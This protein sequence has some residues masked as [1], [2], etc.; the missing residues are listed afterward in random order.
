MFQ[1]ITAVKRIALYGNANE[2]NKVITKLFDN[3]IKV[4]N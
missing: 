3:I 2:Q 1:M 4:L